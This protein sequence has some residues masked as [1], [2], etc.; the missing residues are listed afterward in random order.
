MVFRAYQW[1]RNAEIPLRT[2][3]RNRIMSSVP[4]LTVYSGSAPRKV[5]FPYL[6]L[7]EAG[8]EE[9]CTKTTEGDSIRL[10]FHIYTKEAGYDQ[11]N[12]IWGKI[13]TAFGIPMQVDDNWQIVS[14]GLESGSNVF[15]QGWDV[16]HGV[17]YLRFK[18]WDT[19]N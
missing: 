19:T 5:K 6:I 10:T 17:M 1:K 8:H 4:E 12:D 3:V 13:L 2:S 18:L 14:A 15:R 9:F 11:I 16:S 7:G